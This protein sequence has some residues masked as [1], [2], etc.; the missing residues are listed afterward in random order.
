MG[1]QHILGIIFAIIVLGLLGVYYFA[2][3]DR[4]EFTSNPPNYNF[5]LDSQVSLDNIQFYS[6]MRFPSKYISYKLSNCPLQKQNDIEYAIEIIEN[7]TILDFYP[8]VSDEDLSVSCNETM[9]YEGNM[10]V[11]GEGGPGQ[12]IQSGKYYVIVKAKVLL[13]RESNCE[14]PNIAIHEIF[15]ALGFS[16][17]NNENNIMYNYTHCKQIIGDEI[18]QLINELYAIPSSPN[19]IIENASA[20]I[21]GRYLD[22]NISV[23][24]VGLGD[25]RKAH[26]YVKGGE[27]VIREIDLKELGVGNGVMVGVGNL[28]VNKGIESL[29]LFIDY[30]NEELN[31]TDNNL[32]LE[33][34][35]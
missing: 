6:N 13:I 4:L 15:H 33:L 28:W 21:N 14:R 19:L 11:A 29:E 2:P 26:I 34:K 22:I 3:F 10:F 30:P 24:N 7:L 16:H 35:E 23:R 27:S 32:Y 17:S 25:S 8:V 12:I 20:I 9:R 1:L 18:P 5:S 31:K